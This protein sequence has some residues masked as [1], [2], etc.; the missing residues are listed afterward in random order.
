MSAP[1]RIANTSGFYGDRFSA[2]REMLEGGPVDVLT[3]DY[4]AELTM[5]ILWKARRKDPSAGYATTFV[6]QMEEVMGAC[7][8]RGIRVVTN[9]GGLNPH[10]LAEKLHEVAGRLGLSPRIAVVEGDDLLGRLDG[11]DL[12]HLDTGQKLAE[13]GV[14]PVTAN[15]YLGGWGI[16]AG[17]DAGADIVVTPRVTDAALVVGPAAWWHGWARDD[18]D[19][20]AGAVVAGHVIE[21]GPQATG[22]NYSFLDELPD[23]RYPGFPIAEVADDGSTVITKQPGTGGLVSVGT[24][25]AQLLY[26]IAEPAYANPDVVARFDTI[27]LTQEAPDRVRIAGVRGEPPS[28]LVKVALNHVGGWRNTMTMGLT[29]LDVDAKAERALAMLGDLVGG[30]DQFASWTTALVSTDE[31]AISHLRITVK[32]PDPDKVGRRFSNSVM[33]LL[34][35]SFGGAFTTTPPS[36][37]SEYGVY[38]P[39]LVPSSI[40]EHAVV[41]PDGTRVVVPHTDPVDGPSIPSPPA[42]TWTE[43]GPT[44]RLPLGVVCG[45]RSGDKGGNANIGLWARDDRAHAWLAS[46]LTPDL[47]RSL[48]PEAVDLEVRRFELPNLRALNFVVVGI[49]GEGVASSVR[50][51]PQAKGLGEL[52]RSKLVDI[53]ES[54]LP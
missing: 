41:L 11:H 25:T 15:A 4:L 26:E 31:A 21:C 2:M 6:R 14:E 32:D 23:A 19:R 17:L 35:A 36:A 43:D 37:P 33:E 42:P 1:I 40:V 13:A 48:V 45:A 29:G 8:D 53:P 10:G 22:G 5:L 30:W 28:G 9:A 52:V 44:R 38:W 12:T 34:L 54:L 3:G 50:A 24:V 20:L 39:A 16:A 51:D 47:L 46:T 27:G 7:L 18:W 49:L